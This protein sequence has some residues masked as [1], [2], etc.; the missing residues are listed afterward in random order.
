[1]PELAKGINSDQLY[2]VVMDFEGTTSVA[3][4][5]ASSADS[6]VRLWLDGL[7]TRGSYGLSDSQLARLIEGSRP[8]NLDAPSTPIEGVQ[9]VWCTE[10]LAGSHGMAL[11]NIIATCP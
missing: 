9:G 5:R 3:Q 8:E 11:L 10:V 4:F 7:T 1:M 6:A 2:T